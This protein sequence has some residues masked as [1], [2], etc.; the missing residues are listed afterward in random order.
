VRPAPFLA[1][2][3]LVLGGCLAPS[4]P[5]WTGLGTATLDALAAAQKDGKFDPFLVPYAV[6]AAVRNGIE[7]DTWPPRHPLLDALAVPAGPY[8]A[9]LRPSYALALANP[10]DPDVQSRVRATVLAGFDGI[11]FGD[12]DKTLDDAF[13]LLALAAIGNAASS[14]AAAAATWLVSAA[15]ATGGWSYLA[16]GAPD[17]D[18]TGMVMAALGA[19]GKAGD[20]FGLAFADRAQGTDGG[21]GA[22]PGARSN[23]DSTVW[24]VRAHLVSGAPVPEAAWLFL[25]SLH[26]RDGGWSLHPGEPSN[27]LCSVEVATLFGAAAD[28]RLPVPAAFSFD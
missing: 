9:Q 28:A 3:V 16:H 21:F 17:V 18:S 20:G 10:G 1:A 27:A 14:Q 15:N 7:P 5:T 11:Q 2:A 23:C 26:T 4:A 19:V 22:A 24:A 6:E 13:A 12:A 25:A 8:L